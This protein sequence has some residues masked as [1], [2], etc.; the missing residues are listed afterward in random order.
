M[1]AIGQSENRFTP[2]QLCV[3]TATLANRGTR[4]KATF[5]N[6]VVSSDYSQVT[7]TNKPEILSTFDINNEAYAA[8]TE[9]MRMV[10]TEGTAARFFKDYP[11]AIAAKTG[12]AQTDAGNK[13]S[14]NGAFV[15][16]A[17]Y[18][19]PEIAVVVYGEKAGHGSTMAQIGKTILDT[20]FADRLYG[21]I[22][23]GENQVS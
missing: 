23:P 2:M 5:L 11:I 7:Y 19:E 17:P 3:Y 9:G 12:T 6:R 13:Y 18:D 14:D 20:Y 10:A 15:C 4:Y 1:T 22:T 21:D 16:Y 8:Y